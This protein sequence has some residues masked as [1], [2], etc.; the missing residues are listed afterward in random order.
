MRKIYLP[1]FSS[2]PLSFSRPLYRFPQAGNWYWVLC[3]EE[4]GS[5]FFFVISVHI[6][7]YT[8]SD[9]RHANFESHNY[10]R[11]EQ[12]VTQQLLP[13]YLCSP[14]GSKMLLPF[15]SRVLCCHRSEETLKPLC[16]LCTCYET[17]IKK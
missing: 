3:F 15:A 4:K 16:L 10:Q 14:T 5:R 6:P 1:L 11:P 2:D 7:K 8:A 12:S 17:Y 13:D 9:S